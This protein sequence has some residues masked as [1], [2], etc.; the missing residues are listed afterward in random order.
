MRISGE[1]HIEGGMEID[2][3]AEFIKRIEDK[4]DMVHISCGVEIDNRTK[5]YMSLRHMHRIKSMRKWQNL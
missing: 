1:E 2:E 4:I 3:V 5:I